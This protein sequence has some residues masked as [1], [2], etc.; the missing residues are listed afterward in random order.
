MTEGTIT[1]LRSAIA[2]SVLGAGIMVGSPIQGGDN[3]HQLQANI[4]NDPVKS[5][6][7]KQARKY[8][9]NYP[10]ELVHMSIPDRKQSFMELV[11]PAIENAHNDILRD[12]RTILKILHKNNLSKK[13]QEFLRQ[14]MDEYGVKKNSDFSE[15]LKHVDI[16]PASMAVA[17]AALESGWGASRLAQKTNGIFGQKGKNQCAIEATDGGTH[18]CFDSFEDSVLAYMN[19]LNTNPSYR[20]FREERHAMRKA[21]GENSSLDGYSLMGTL[22]RYSIRKEEY[23]EQIRGFMKSNGFLA[24]DNS[25]KLPSIN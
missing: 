4:T 1:I 8:A 12:R 10:I 16:V 25:I 5:T 19:N 14:K 18:P 6:P 17:Q 21:K 13:D 20:E 7:V 3:P 23:I 9:P 15:L 24:F 11:I 22:T 2:A